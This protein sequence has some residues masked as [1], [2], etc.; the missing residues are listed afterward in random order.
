MKRKKTELMEKLDEINPEGDKNELPTKFEEMDLLKY[1]LLVERSARIDAQLTNLTEQRT[2]VNKELE[3]VGA[4]LTIKYKLSDKR[5]VNIETG[6]I[7]TK[8]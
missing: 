2:R 1:Q 6:E 8:D 4:E 5:G 7:V 3:T